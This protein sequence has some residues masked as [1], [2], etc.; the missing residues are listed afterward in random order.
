MNKLATV[1]FENL[2]AHLFFK[3]Y[4][5]FNCGP[6]QDFSHFGDDTHPTY[7]HGQT[8]EAGVNTE[9]PCQDFAH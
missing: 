7:S 8:R 1:A 3:V 6:P 9:R 2:L 5:S 4:R